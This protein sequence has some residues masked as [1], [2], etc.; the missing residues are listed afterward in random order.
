MAKTV[1]FRPGSALGLNVGIDGPEA[2]IA[3]KV[4]VSLDFIKETWGPSAATRYDLAMN[5]GRTDGARWLK[6]ISPTKIPF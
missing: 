2:L 5:N 3:Q 1:E 6:Q 4:H